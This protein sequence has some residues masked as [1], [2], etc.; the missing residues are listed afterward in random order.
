MGGE[1]QKERKITGHHLALKMF[2]FLSRV[3]F[4]YADLGYLRNKL[5]LTVVIKGPKERVHIGAQVDLQDAILNT[6]SGEIFI[7]D[8][9]FCGQGCMILT[10]THDPLLH[11]RDRQ[12]NH[13]KEGYDIHIGSGVWIS[14]G[15]I[16]CGNVRIAD[17]AVIAAGSVVVKDC[18]EPA[19]YGGIPA[20][21]IKNLEGFSFP[22][23]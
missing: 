13:P 22:K 9:T 11:N 8:H 20:R 7:G 23:T 6:N 21:K 14:S 16:I 15:A 1:C 3:I 18:L 10:G 4:K 2:K 12:Q 17:N 19:L 5:L